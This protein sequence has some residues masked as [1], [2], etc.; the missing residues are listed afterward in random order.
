VVEKNQ[1]VGTLYGTGTQRFFFSVV[2]PKSSYPLEEKRPSNKY[3][4]N[5]QKIT[6]IA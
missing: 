2:L 6:G 1:N 5:N 4:T 3:N